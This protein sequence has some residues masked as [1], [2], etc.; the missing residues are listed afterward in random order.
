LFGLSLSIP[1][2]VFASGLLAKVMDNYPVIV[3]T[4]AA[5]LGRVAGQMIMR[6]AFTVQILA[7]G[8]ELDYSVEAGGATQLA[9]SSWEYGSTLTAPGVATSQGD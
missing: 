8:A 6:D 3:Y 1:L 2:V 9:W 7:P 5:L 4:G